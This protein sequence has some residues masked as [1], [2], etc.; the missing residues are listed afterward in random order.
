MAIYLTVFLAVLNQ[1]SLKGSKMLMSLF[2]L[3]LGAPPPAVG[4]LASLYA[5]FPMLLAIH[6]GRISD[7]IGVRWPMVGGG[8]GLA[9]GL[10]LPALWPTLPALYL[11]AALIGVG[12]IFFH[13][14]VHNLIG[15]FGD[16]SARTR[17]FG[18]F[19]LG[20]SIS[21]MA[22]PILV[23]ALIDHAGYAPS[24]LALA[25]IA[26]APALVLLAAPGFI[27]PTIRPAKE[28]QA[29]GVR[30]LLGDKSLRGTYITS[31]LIL[32]G[33]DLFN[34]YMPIYGRGIGL[35]ASHIGL[36]L[37]MQAAAAFVVRLGMGS[38]ARRI[39]EVRMLTGCL[40]MSGL[41]YFLFPVFR[42][43]YVLALISFLLGLGL[44][45]GQP[46]SIIMTYNHSPPGRA[47]EA[48][49]VRLTVN[50]FTQIMVP[51][52]FGSLGSA[53][54]LYPIFWSNAVLLLFGGWLNARRSKADASSGLQAKPSGGR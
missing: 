53:L 44:G 11:S 45:C 4:L 41:T 22:G 9:L 10:L 29:G 27:P 34:F 39:G 14:S 40:L 43:P 33:I 15:S 50:K 26:L 5:V 24:S 48:L 12:N 49:G 28:E 30:E 2:A 46:L 51:L 7:R 8:T 36:I 16:A 13:V 47:G 37:G 21:G 17:N 42:D 1:I 20:A 18:T 38:M 3:H 19:S 52:L 31:G 25:G 32:T 35:D 23:G 6:A 54:G